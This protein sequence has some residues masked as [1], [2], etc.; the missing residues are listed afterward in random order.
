M[1]FRKLATLSKPLLNPRFISP[2]FIKPSLAPSFRAYATAT[3]EELDQL[4]EATSSFCKSEIPPS[5]AAETDSSNAFPNSLWP[6]MGDAGLLGITAKEEYGG[7]DAGYV[8]HLAVM[9]EISKASGSI[10]LSYIAHSNLCIN[11]LTRYVTPEQG[12]KYLPDLIAG[13][14]IGALAMSEANSGSDVVS[15]KLVAKETDDK[16]GYILNGTKLWITNGPDAD[17]LVVY[18]KTD[19]EAGVKGISTF[20]VEKSMPGFSVSRKLDKLGMRGSN[21]G[22]LVFED[23]FVPKENLLGPLNKGVYVLMS[24]LDYERL[25]LCGGPLGLMKAAIDESFQY[26]HER[27]QFGKPIAHFQLLQGKM[28]DMYSKYAASRAYV[29]ECARAADKN[30]LSSRD[31][32]AAL[33]YSAER[34]T[35]VCQDAIQLMGGM[36][37]VSET[38]VGRMWRDAKLYEIGGGTTEVRKIVIGRSFNKEYS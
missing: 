8:A 13:R 22:E 28:A 16:S 5:L 4:R 6:K 27:Q 12:Q 33:M 21:T 2:R 29:Y 35:E 14:K 38:G 26:A 25:L 3:A 17:T 36:G 18:A 30:E 11:Q 7:L 19:P 34:A 24:G 10:G 1:S 23:C 37:Y 32:A 20:I 31:S 9:E 15:M